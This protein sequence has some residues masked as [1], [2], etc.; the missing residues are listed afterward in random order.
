VYLLK[1]DT[2]NTADT[3]YYY[4]TIIS[5]YLTPVFGYFTFIRNEQIFTS[6]TTFPHLLISALYSDSSNVLGVVIH[7]KKIQKQ[8]QKVKV[9]SLVLI[10]HY[11]TKMYGI[12]GKYS[13]S[14]S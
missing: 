11:A 13:V 1:S 7:I 10:K 9:T 14:L 6:A 5:N 2:F 8:K 3:T 4:T 12:A